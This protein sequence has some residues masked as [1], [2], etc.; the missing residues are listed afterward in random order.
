MRH[1]LKRVAHRRDDAL[2]GMPWDRL[3][4]LL[5]AFYRD[6]GDQVTHVGTGATSGRFDGGVN[7]ELR[8]DGV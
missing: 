4:Y 1:G 6:A 2:T 3:E 7:L 5:A 8:R